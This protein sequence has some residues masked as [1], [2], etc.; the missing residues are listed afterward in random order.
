VTQRLGVTWGYLFL[1]ADPFGLVASSRV[2]GLKPE[3]A[4]RLIRGGDQRWC[5]ALGIEH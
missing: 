1:V 3:L 4:A 2:T 5:L